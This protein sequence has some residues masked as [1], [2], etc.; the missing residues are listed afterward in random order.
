M[1]LFADGSKQDVT[2][3]VTWT[4]S[5]PSVAT[6]SNQSG[7]IGL[8]QTLTAGSTTIT[9]N[10]PGGSGAAT[11]TVT[12]A[13]IS[14]IAVTPASPS[15]A[16]GSTQQFKA[17]A[18]L[19]DKT[20]QDVTATS[21]W[22]SSNQAVATISN[23]SGSQG[24][25]QAKGLG[26]STITAALSG[27]SGTV[28]LTVTAPTLTAITVTPAA[29]SIAKGN[30]QQFTAMATFSDGTTQDVTQSANWTSTN[31]KVAS[32]SN[33]AGTQGLA[34]A[35]LAGTTSIGASYNNV[36]GAT[37][38]TVTAP[39]MTSIGITPANP[40]L[41][42]G[43]SAQFTATATFSD[44]TT[45]NITQTATWA[46]SDQTVANVSNAAGSN[47]FA[48]SVGAGATT[49]SATL[50]S[51]SGSTR[52]T[53]TGA[54]AA[55]L[56]ISPA[57][58]SVAKGLTQQFTATA[59][60]DDGSTQDV[61]TSA[62]WGSS[63]TKVA[64]ISNSS[65]SNG[66]ASTLAAGTAT[67]SA[68]YNGASATAS[69]TVT[70]ASLTTIQI[71]PGAPRLPAG[72]SRQLQAT[73]HYSDGT[74]RDIT[75]QVTWQSG[76]TAVLGIGNDAGTQGLA[77]G[78]KAG[79]SLVSAALGATAASLTV[80][81]TSS[82]LQSLQ[83]TPFTSTIPSG[84]TLQYT[85]IGV[86]SDST[87]LDL[88]TQVS[89]QSSSTAVA[90][91]SNAM[92][93]NGLAKGTA[94]GGPITITAQSGA[95]S[96]TGTLT[97]TAATL[98]SLTIAAT[99]NASTVP[100]G[101]NLQ[102]KATGTFSDGSASDLTSAVTWQ[103]SNAAT[104]SI[105][106]AAG[107]NGLVTGVAPGTTSVSAVQGSVSSSTLKLT[108]TSATLQSISIIPT[109]PSVPAGIKQQLSATG[110][111]SDGS[112]RDLTAEAVWQSSNA[113]AVSVSNAAGSSGLASALS[114]GLA[115]IS[116]SDS[117][118][119]QQVSFTV[120]AAT[121]TSIVVTP[122]TGSV[123][124]NG[125]VQLTATGSYSDGTS[126]D[127]TGQLTWTSSAAGVAEVANA[128]G[129]QGLAFG[130]SAGT[131]TVTATDPATGLSGAAQLTVTGS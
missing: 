11:L 23:A 43:T 66:L 121:L 89:W 69:L 58:A 70:A 42:K 37:T 100:N 120:T 12:A 90:Q 28:T 44:G 108:V 96:A 87:T 33:T 31:A 19:S 81:V 118:V 47:G 48:Q 128:P 29:P 109:A 88:T 72:Y 38:L 15:V 77:T 68:T 80:T 10:Y 3:L 61:T 53:V 60:F 95:V 71:T 57:S 13:T 79:S 105:S 116:A 126:R 110:T 78:L 122:S 64:S 50:N 27:Q 39:V 56:T 65:G 94:Q 16:N 8:A 74:K 98:K 21:T 93:S 55:S 104:A 111:Y 25:A 59:T 54:Q 99:G 9:A 7:S 115:T 24:L 123:A 1:A 5:D 6:I 124:V 36:A 130:Q 52:L 106:N 91:V 85:A 22:S 49:I 101:L 117:G 63:N 82:T 103:S 67:I 92:G 119:T 107:S 35:L 62:T 32:I 131:A 112:Q 20:T 84:T 51:L 75:T 127:L 34:Q 102:Y 73:G 40:V 14:S 2:S 17:T 125:S 129:L 97:V 4:S 113:V 18:T 41:A 45:Q 46:S 83:V 86:F 30:K 26:T 76:D 114:Q